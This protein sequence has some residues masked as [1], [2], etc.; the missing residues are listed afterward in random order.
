MIGV[1]AG[2]IQNELKR[3]SDRKNV[4]SHVME[5]GK[6][7]T[8]LEQLIGEADIVISLL[9]YNLHPIVAK[10]CIASKKNLVTSSYLLPEM[11]ALHTAFVSTIYNI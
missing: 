11:K 7:A 10:L 9:P 3:F 8:A 4:H 6:D 1:A 5:V 2:P